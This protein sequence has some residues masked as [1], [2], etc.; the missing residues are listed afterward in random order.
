MANIEVNG[1]YRKDGK[2]VSGHFRKGFRKSEDLLP[3]DKFMADEYP[4]KHN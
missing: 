2:F 4:E 1:Y 3:Q